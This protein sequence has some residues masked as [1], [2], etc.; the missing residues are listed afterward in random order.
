MTT[1]FLKIFLIYLYTFKTNLD[2]ANKEINN[3]EN[4][5]DKIKI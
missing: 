1:E 2:M 5:L 4:N 3:R